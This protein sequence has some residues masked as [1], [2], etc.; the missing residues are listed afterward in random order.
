MISDRRRALCQTLLADE[1]LSS[2]MCMSTS[3]MIVDSSPPRYDDTIATLFYLSSSVIYLA[4]VCGM[5]YLGA[6]ARVSKG[7]NHHLLDIDILVVGHGR[8]ACGPIWSVYD[9][10]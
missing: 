9:E 10:R 5:M 4:L 1:V 7:S 6:N 2:S 3:V 8:A